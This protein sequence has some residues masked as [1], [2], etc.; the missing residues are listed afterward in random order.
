MKTPTER[1]RDWYAAQCNGDWEH[2]NGVKIHTTDNPGWWVQIDL[3]GT[4]AQSLYGKGKR[5][6]LTWEVER[7]V[8]YGYDEETGDLDGLLTLLMDLIESV[9][10]GP[11]PGPPPAG[12]A[13]QS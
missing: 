9:I 1:L 5:G 12:G 4:T 6:E 3:D 8:L 13:S 7:R 10:T 11:S 2:M